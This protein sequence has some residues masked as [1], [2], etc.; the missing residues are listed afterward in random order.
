M[1]KS[2]HDPRAN[3]P[4]WVDHEPT[5]EQRR[6]VGKMAGYGLN[7]DM[8]APVIGVCPKTLR[9]YYR[10]ELDSAMIDKIAV[11][12]GC[13]YVNATDN[14]DF[15]SQRFFLQTQGGK[16]WNIPQQ[17]K[18][19]GDENEDSIKV[20]LDGLPTLMDRITSETE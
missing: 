6:Q 3:N 17:L 12:A 1:D 4:D 2:L 20:Q 11:V 8:I 14:M 15:K 13:L 18:L 16:G 9:K 7:Q 10:E 5:A 19:T